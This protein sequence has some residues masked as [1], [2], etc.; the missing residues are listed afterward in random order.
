VPIFI[1]PSAIRGTYAY[2]LKPISCTPPSDGR[3]VRF[4]LPIGASVMVACSGNGN[5]LQQRKTPLAMFECNLD[6]NNNAILEEKGTHVKANICDTC[7]KI[8]KAK[9]L[10]S[11]YK[12]LHLFEMALV[13]ANA[14]KV[15]VLDGVLDKNYNALISRT[16][17]DKNTDK[18]SCSD[19]RV[20]KFRLDGIFPTD[21]KETY[22][23]DW[24]ES[25]MLS[26]CGSDEN[27]HYKVLDRLFGQGPAWSP[28]DNDRL[29]RG[30]LTANADQIFKFQQ[31][32]TFTYVNAAP[33]WQKTNGKI[34]LSVENKV[35]KIAATQQVDLEVTTGTFDTLTLPVDCAGGT[36]A[37][38][39]IN[40]NLI[41]KRVATHRSIDNREY[42]VPKI[43]Y[44][45][46]CSP[47]SGCHV[48]VNFNT[49]QTSSQLDKDDVL[50]QTLLSKNCKPEGD[51]SQFYFIC[52]EAQ[53]Y[54]SIQCSDD[55]KPRDLLTL[56]P[57]F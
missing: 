54:D 2:L 31:H 51:S 11:K 48:F 33:Q 36:V 56:L 32:A 41:L 22:G 53:F 49:L 43:F 35:R 18:L 20:E 46:V 29:V 42:R 57:N 9:L 21:I 27:N 37:N 26:T 15:K 19:S 7:S 45:I 4:S 6:H 28:C 17:I 25:V 16:V 44:K 38:K 10:T 14:L 55:Y 30:H 52:T 5:F 23:D 47:K 40:N 13:L 8:Q 34:W 1:D 12:D 50:F 39:D 3:C 24:P